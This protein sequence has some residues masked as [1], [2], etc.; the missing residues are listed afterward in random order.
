MPK[1]GSSQGRFKKVEKLFSLGAYRQNG[2]VSQRQPQATAFA[3]SFGGEMGKGAVMTL[4]DAGLRHQSAQAFVP[5][6]TSVQ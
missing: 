3:I 5:L 1:D 6:P 4:S 2:S